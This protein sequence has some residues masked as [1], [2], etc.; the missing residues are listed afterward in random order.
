M[1]Y[2]VSEALQNTD[3]DSSA[4]CMTAGPVATD[5]TMSSGFD[6]S[7]FLT[8]DTSTKAILNVLKA[9]QVADSAAGIHSHDGSII[10]W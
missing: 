9:V 10:A 6:V 5:M 4:Y 1:L 3:L 2:V 8:V 7:Q